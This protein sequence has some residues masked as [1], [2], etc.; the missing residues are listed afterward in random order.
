VPQPGDYP[1]IMPTRRIMA[2]HAHPDDETIT[3][4]GTLARYAGAGVQI[5]LVTATLGEEGEVIGQE[6][7]GLTAANADQLGGY[8]CAE[9]RV[10]CAA[11]GITDHRMLGGLGTYRDSGMI[12]TPPAAHPRAFVRAGT[13]GPAHQAAV[14]SLVE[15]IEQ[16]R[17]DVLLTYDAD[18]GYGHPD[19]I[20]THQVAMAAG[21]ARVSRIFA[22]VR[23][24]E[25]SL[26]ALAEL[27]VPAGYVRGTSGDLG[28]LASSGRIHAAVAGHSSA[29]LAALHAH[30]SQ[31]TVIPGG[32]A[33]SNN[34]A[35]PSFGTEYFTLLAGEPMPA[36]PVADDLFAGLQ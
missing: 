26:A 35:Q 13:G 2:V 27:A 14:R 22:V 9:L 16:T 5:T 28:Y 20:T 23:T 17:P 32:F 8:R 30:Q 7:Q 6:L 10:A 3:M 33:L 36:G 24:R 11:L 29:R 18:G 12:G 34:I 4:G 19:H 25:V 21:A 1:S 15:I 31:L